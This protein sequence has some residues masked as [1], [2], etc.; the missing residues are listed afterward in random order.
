MGKYDQIIHLNRPLDPKHPPM[1]LHNRAAQFAPF[2]ALTGFGSQIYETSR[3]TD[4]KKELSEEIKSEIND[5]LLQLA[6][7]IHE[8]PEVTVTYFIPDKTKDGGAYQTIT[9]SAVKLNIYDEYLILK[10]DLRI[11]FD[12]ILELEF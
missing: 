10:N 7:H 3:R 8:Q 4:K 2:D 9:A 6:K 11:S 5:K 12:D 1:S